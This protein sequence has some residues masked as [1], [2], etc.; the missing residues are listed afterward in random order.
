M[1]CISFTSRKIFF[2]VYIYLLSQID[3]NQLEKA[4]SDVGLETDLSH[5][6]LT[7]DPNI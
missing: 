2:N 3:V 1:F 4:F 7:R 5:C 6:F